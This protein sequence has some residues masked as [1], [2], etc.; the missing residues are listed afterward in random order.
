MVNDSWGN[1]FHDF[2]MSFIV[3]KVSISN[4]LNLTSHTCI[5][6]FISL[7]TTPHSINVCKQDHSLL[8][9][10]KLYFCFKIS[11][12]TWNFS[13]KILLTVVLQINHFHLTKSHFF[14]GSKAHLDQQVHTDYQVALHLCSPK[15][16]SIKKI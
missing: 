15:T 5:G 13:I 14:V 16:F 1:K 4:N 8:E 2:S 6:Q 11:Y 3:R 10:G 9:V 12:F 7:L